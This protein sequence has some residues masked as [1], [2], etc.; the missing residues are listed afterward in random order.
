M[1]EGDHEEDTAHER[2]RRLRPVGETY[3]ETP[4]PVV[5]MDA[6]HTLD[7]LAPKPD[8]HVLD[9]GCGTGRHLGPMIFLKQPGRRRLFARDAERCIA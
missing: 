5:A 3:D 1:L 8:E 7:A 6:R 9:A 2:A 4:N